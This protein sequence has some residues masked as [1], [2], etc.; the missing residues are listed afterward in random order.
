ML[1]RCKKLTPL[2]ILSAVF[3]FTVTGSGCGDEE[4]KVDLSKCYRYCDM[5]GKCY[6]ELSE[7][8][9]DCKKKC[10]QSGNKGSSE[11][12]NPELIRCAEKYS[13]CEG[14]IDCVESVVAR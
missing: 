10:K 2:I 13:E 4:E 11:T 1:K 5:K 8:V 3:L 9:G 14:F 7:S 12:A 6:P